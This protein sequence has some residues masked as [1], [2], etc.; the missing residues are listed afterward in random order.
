MFCESL[1][2]RQRNGRSTKLTLRGR[3][4]AM[5]TARHWDRL[6]KNQP[7]EIT[8]FQISEVQESPAFNGRRS[9]LTLRACVVATPQNQV[10][11]PG[12]YHQFVLLLHRGLRCPSQQ[13][14]ES[15]T[16]KITAGDFKFRPACGR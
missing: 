10:V 1:S 4:R 2:F 9:F 12:D 16:V 3:Q 8:M 5:E 13:Q 7:A 6:A 14:A 11:G 15:Q